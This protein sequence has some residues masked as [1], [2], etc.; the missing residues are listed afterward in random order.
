MQIY[1][2]YIYSNVFHVYLAA[3][4]LSCST[5]DLSVRSSSSPLWRVGSSCLTRDGGPGR[6]ALGMQGLSHWVARSPS[7]LPISPFGDRQV[8]KFG[9]SCWGM[10]TTWNARQAVQAED[11]YTVQ[12]DSQQTLEGC[13]PCVIHPGM[14]TATSKTP[15]LDRVSL[16][17]I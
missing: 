17:T 8:K 9:L 11:S 3:A 15:Y 1:I 2:L 5:R 12:W 13:H 14:L 4:G 6:P 7:M 16:K 10:K